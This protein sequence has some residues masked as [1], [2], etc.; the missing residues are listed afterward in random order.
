MLAA[1]LHCGADVWEVGRG[2]R[3]DY[4]MMKARN[5]LRE[6]VA[7]FATALRSEAKECHDPE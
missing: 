6:A 5:K 7:R 2:E 1:P 4:K 3:A